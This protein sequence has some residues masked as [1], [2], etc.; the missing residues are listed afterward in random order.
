MVLISLGGSDHWHPLTA[1]LRLRRPPSGCPD[2]QLL[3]LSKLRPILRLSKEEFP[4]R[5]IARASG[6]PFTLTSVL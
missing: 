1:T 5:F 3:A 6:V 2:F 4:V